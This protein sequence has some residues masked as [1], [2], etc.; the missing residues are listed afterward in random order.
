MKKG[1]LLIIMTCFFSIVLIN[2]CSHENVNPNIISFRDTNDKLLM[3][4]DVIKYAK[5][6][7]DAS[8]RPCIVLK[9]SDTKKFHDITKTISK[10]DDN[11]L[12]IWYKFDENKNSFKDSEDNCGYLKDPSCLS[13]A[14]VSQAFDNDE[15]LIIGS[16]TEEEV[17]KMV[18]KINE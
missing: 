12:V 15:I 14:S 17:N 16:F 8:N 1:K 4:G 9:I 13:T 7:K 3:S 11:R 18:K 2:G 10:K 6:G 5:A